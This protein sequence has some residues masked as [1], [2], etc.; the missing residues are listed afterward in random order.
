M[1]NNVH[2]KTK[3]ETEVSERIFNIEY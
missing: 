3:Q 2:A 1:Q